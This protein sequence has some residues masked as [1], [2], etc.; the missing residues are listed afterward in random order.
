MRHRA[1]ATRSPSV[2]TLVFFKSYFYDAMLRNGVHNHA[3][4]AR[5]S[6]H[7]PTIMAADI[8]IPCHVG[9]DRWVLAVIKP[10]A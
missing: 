7:L 6:R 8:Y 1:Q 4:V 2:P 5:W 10:A 3:N 9:G